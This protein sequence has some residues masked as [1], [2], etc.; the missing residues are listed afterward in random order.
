MLTL[1]YKETLVYKY[2]CSD[3]RFHNLGGM[4]LLFWETIQRAKQAGLRELDLGRSDLDNAGLVQFKGHLGAACSSIAY[5]RYPAPAPASSVRNWASGTV[6]YG[7]SLL[8]D[9][10]LIP[11]GNFLYKHLG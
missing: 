3:E 4:P 5:Y 1:A 8:P 11:I 6:R 2:G 10:G 7:L 9:W